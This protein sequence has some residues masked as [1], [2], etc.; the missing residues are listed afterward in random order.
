MPLEISLTILQV[1]T[2][3]Q[4][5]KLINELVAQ[6]K[7]LATQLKEQKAQNEKLVSRIKILEEKLNTNSRNSSK[8]PSSDCSKP[9]TPD[10]SRNEK[11]QGAQP[12][13][14]GEG[15]D[16]F[17]AEK[18]DKVHDCPPAVEC[19][20]GGHINTTHLIT[21]HQ[22]IEI[23]EISSYFRNATLAQPTDLQLIS[24]YFLAFLTKHDHTRL[25]INFNNIFSSKLSFENLLGKRILNL[26][27]YRTL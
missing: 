13:H 27:L 9:A 4:A 17:P 11:K 18:I 16:L 26:G 22:T 14:K 6:N 20:C 8:P 5:Q 7:E 24:I 10:K 15:R 23:P 25:Y 3:E 1:A 19:D 12:G 2:L 21:R